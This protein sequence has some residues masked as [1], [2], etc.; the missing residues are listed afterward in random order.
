[1]RF[2]YTYKSYRGYPEATE[3]S[4]D[5]EE[6]KIPLT[7]LSGLLVIV[8][9]IALFV[10]FMNSWYIAL[11]LLALG[12]LGIFY[13]IKYYDIVTERKVKRAIKRRDEMIKKGRGVL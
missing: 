11:C 1:M 13:I 12:G 8:G 7:I 10:D 2:Q 9:L 3:I 6:K 5:R 4:R